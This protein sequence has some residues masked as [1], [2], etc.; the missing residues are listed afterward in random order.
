MRLASVSGAAL[1]ARP[2][3]GFRAGPGREVEFPRPE[4]LFAA[5]D[6]RQ[7]TLSRTKWRVEVY[8]VVDKFGRRWIQLALN[9]QTKIMLTLR[10]AAGAGARHV[11][12]VLSSWLSNPSGSPDILNVA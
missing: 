2:A 7:V 5:L 10:L 9:G 6:G 12:F 4:D 8:S 3:R 11:V 1:G